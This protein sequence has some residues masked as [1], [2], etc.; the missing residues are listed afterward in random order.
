MTIQRSKSTTKKKTPLSAK[1]F[2]IF[3]TKDTFE[4][5]IAKRSINNRK[6]ETLEDIKRRS[7]FNINE[8]QK[9]GFKIERDKWTGVTVGRRDVISNLSI[10]SYHYF[11]FIE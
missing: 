4:I 8:R 9:I 7:N 10:Q 11:N 2:E 5:A 3:A 6:L 1:P